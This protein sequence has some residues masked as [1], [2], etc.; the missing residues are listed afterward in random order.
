[1]TR[2]EKRSNIGTG[3]GM[4]DWTKEEVFK[5]FQ[6]L[7]DSY[8]EMDRKLQKSAP[9]C[10]FTTMSVDS[11]DYESWWECEHCGHTKALSETTGER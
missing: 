3:E 9:I 4:R 5:A 11:S 6:G 1:M 7:D 10:H 8:A 2:A